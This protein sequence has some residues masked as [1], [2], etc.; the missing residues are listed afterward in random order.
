VSSI[1]YLHGFADG[2]NDLKG[3]YCRAWA[4]SRGIE[5]YGPD[6]NLPAFESLTIS[7]QVDAVETL[8]RQLESTAV[9]IGSSLGG[10]IAAAVGHRIVPRQRS[11]LKALILLAPAFGFAR[12][13]L[14]SELWADYRRRGNLPI[15]HSGMQRWMCLGPQ[16]LDDLPAWTQAETWQIE[17]PVFV[18]HGRRD[19]IVPLAESDAFVLRH[20]RARLLVLE[21]A[22][23]LSTESSIDAL[24]G[25]LSEVFTN[26]EFQ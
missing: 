24:G 16:L 2:P 10:L 17:M 5:F 7:A 9:L 11:W 18:L 15:W 8:V 13:R 1:I 12:R 26:P 14:E 22:H 21:D 6:L 4:G 3:Q 20:P 19:E 23:E 25:V